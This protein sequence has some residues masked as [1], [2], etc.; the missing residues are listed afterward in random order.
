MDNRRR[1]RGCVGESMDMGH[2]IMS[3]LLLVH[4]SFPKINI[5]KVSAHFLYLVLFYIQPQFLL[6]LC[7]CKPKPAPRAELFLRSE[8]FRHF[9]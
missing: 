6:R 4:A 8:K 1:F 3:E 9:F 2:N 7:K 5:L